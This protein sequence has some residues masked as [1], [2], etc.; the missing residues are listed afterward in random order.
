MSTDIVLVH[1]VEMDE[2]D[3]QENKQQTPFQ[4]GPFPPALKLE[5]GLRSFQPLILV[6]ILA[7][8]NICA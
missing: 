1:E 8:G 4:E 3:G 6:Q 2:M 5:G 7:G